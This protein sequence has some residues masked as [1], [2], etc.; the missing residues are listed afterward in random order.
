MALLSHS[1]KKDAL[2]ALTHSTSERLVKRT[3]GL[4][5]DVANVKEFDLRVVGILMGLA[6]NPRY[7]DLVWEWQV[8]HYDA[9]WEI[10]G[11][12][13]VRLF[14]LDVCFSDLED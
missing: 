6:A 5:D 2:F 12:S 1:E 3:L 4:I 14:R 11:G 13:L 9:L 7:K 10:S 8:K